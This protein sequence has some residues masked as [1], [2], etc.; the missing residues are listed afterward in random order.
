MKLMVCAL[1]LLSVSCAGAALESLQGE[2]GILETEA[3]VGEASSVGSRDVICSASSFSR[4]E[5]ERAAKQLCSLHKNVI[6]GGQAVISKYNEIGLEWA[7]A[8]QVLFGEGGFR[9]I[10][11]RCPEYKERME[12]SGLSLQM[13]AA[14]DLFDN[15]K[16]FNA[17]KVSLC[18]RMW[19]KKPF[20]EAFSDLAAV[21]GANIFKSNSLQRCIQDSAEKSWI[22]ED[23]LACAAACLDGDC[24]SEMEHWDPQYYEFLRKCRWSYVQ[25]VSYILDLL[26]PLAHLLQEGTTPLCK[27]A[28]NVCK[29]VNDCRVYFGG[30]QRLWEEVSQVEHLGEMTGALKALEVVFTQNKTKLGCLTVFQGCC[31]DNIWLELTLC[32]V[33]AP[34][35][36]KGN[37]ESISEWVDVME[38]LKV[39]PVQT[40]NL[41]LSYGVAICEGNWVSCV[42]GESAGGTYYNLYHGKD[43]LTFVKHSLQSSRSFL[44]KGKACTAFEAYMRI[45][46]WR[47][48]FNAWEMLTMLMQSRC[49]YNGQ[50]AAALQLVWEQIG[51]KEVNLGDVLQ[52]LHGVKSLSCTPQTR[53]NAAQRTSS[54]LV[55]FLDGKNIWEQSDK[56]VNVD[57]SKVDAL[58]CLLYEL[59][60]MRGVPFFKMLLACLPKSWEKEAVN[61]AARD[62]GEASLFKMAIES[63]TNVAV[64]VGGMVYAEPQVGMLSQEYGAFLEGKITVQQCFDVLRDTATTLNLPQTVVQ[65]NSDSEQYY[66][67]RV[68]NVIWHIIDKKGMRNIRA[69]LSY[70]SLLILK[71][72]ATPHVSREID[73]VCAHLC[74]VG[75][76]SAAYA[77]LQNAPELPEG[78]VDRYQ[79]AQRLLRPWIMT[80]KSLGEEY[81]FLWR[82]E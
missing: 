64:I 69:L 35:K 40:L 20:A 43:I 31:I 12:G 8:R 80:Q 55:K 39:D 18:A 17:L 38:R 67:A 50:N 49:R 30:G 3:P 46:Q 78:A 37:F 57:M 21:V 13:R 58:I 6:A 33:D 26:Q 7:R 56:I 22:C 63:N 44:F 65:G 10:A 1:M 9:P 5:I 45:L 61:R 14:L 52:H 28:R 25:R 73:R 75:H 51:G 34:C 32:C 59:D 27:A 4:E 82:D 66:R 41:M 2:G 16:R 48:H 24:V 71:V 81:A 60:R 74:R 62:L 36:I 53:A 77:F 54:E 72:E 19:K 70:L 42:S 23:T 79:Q 11:F 29:T 15:Q 68:S 76:K 47:G